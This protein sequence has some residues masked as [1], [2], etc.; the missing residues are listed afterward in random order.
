MCLNVIIEA[1]SRFGKSDSLLFL[2]SVSVEYTFSTAG[3]DGQS[4]YNGEIASQ[5]RETAIPF[6]LDVRRKERTSMGNGKIRTIF[7]IIPPI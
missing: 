5:K 1:R 7:C 3:V 2:F 6:Y 4:L